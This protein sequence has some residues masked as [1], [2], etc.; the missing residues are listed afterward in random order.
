MT[1]HS[2]PTRIVLIGYRGTGKTSV[3]QLV[4]Q[5]LGYQCLDADVEL[6]RTAGSTIKQIFESEGEEGFRQREAAVVD[7]LCQR[8]NVVL[9]LGGGAVLRKT[10]RETIA[11][12]GN[13]VVWLHAP[14]ETLYHRIHADATS[15][16]RRPSLTAR[17]ALEEIEHLLKV[18]EPLYR[19]CA[20]WKLDTQS[21]S[22]A[23]VADAIVEHIHT[24]S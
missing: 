15:A 13:F 3:G 21:K 17:G 7:S 2:I 23:E 9:A 8:T 1:R 20:D 19:E 11:Q 10:N 16:T 4:A 6:E 22:L 12:P 5:S 18:R 24:Q 14:A